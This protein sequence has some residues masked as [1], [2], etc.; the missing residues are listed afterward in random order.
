MITENF[1]SENERENFHTLFRQTPEMVCILR[2]PDHVFE[3]VNSAHIKV[4]GFDATGKN[5]REAQPESIEVYSIL[6][7]V[8]ASGKTAHLSEIRVTFGERL[9]L[10]DLTYSARRALNGSTGRPPSRGQTFSC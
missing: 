4:L 8:Y 1:A 6:D 2:G 3:F 10:F 7:N 9:R 5:V